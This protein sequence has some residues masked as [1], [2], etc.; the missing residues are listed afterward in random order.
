[1]TW[2]ACLWEDCHPIRDNILQSKKKRSRSSTTLRL[3]RL[4]TRWDR[5]PSYQ[6]SKSHKERA[7][8]QLVIQTCR[9]NSK[10]HSLMLNPWWSRDTRWIRSISSKFRMPC[11]NKTLCTNKSSSSKVK[12]KPKLMRICSKVK[13]VKHVE[14][15]NRNKSYSLKDKRRSFKHQV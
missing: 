3:S 6:P 15:L 13:W 10:A 9:E 4:V 5:A 2:W 1:M 8:Y 14:G 11:L 12:M 7:T